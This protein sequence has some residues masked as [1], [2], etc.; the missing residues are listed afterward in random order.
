MENERFNAY[1]DAY[2]KVYET[3]YNDFDKFIQCFDVWVDVNRYYDEPIPVKE[4]NWQQ[5]EFTDWSSLVNCVLE[6]TR[7]TQHLFDFEL[8]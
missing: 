7:Q 4:P 5:F 8:P 2:D 1:S 3:L 6:N